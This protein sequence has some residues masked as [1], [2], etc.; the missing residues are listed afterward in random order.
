MKPGNP[1]LKRAR[2]FTLIELLVVIAIIAILAG[3][4]LPALSNAKER[5]HRT[6]CTNNLRQLGIALTMY[7]DDS[8]DNLPPPLFYPEQRP[9]SEPWQGY[10]VFVGNDGQRADTSVPFNLGYLYT[11]SYIDAHKVFYDP[12]MKAPRDIPIKLQLEY[13]EG[14]GVSWPKV[15]GGRV[16][17]N[18]M[19]FPQSRQPYSTT[20][21]AGQEEWRR[22]ARKTSELTS[23]YTITTDL[24]YTEATR[25]HT[26][27]KNPNG[28]NALFG[29][30]HV[31]FSSSS[32]AFAPELW[33]GGKH[34]VGK[35]NPGDNP[36]KFRTIVALLRP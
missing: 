13:Y 5:A 9:S 3:M 28:I 20:P 7:A 15:H 17:I 16:R 4:L 1:N 6:S 31:S 10:Q 11:G 21:S 29:D 34:H 33:D 32:A 8:G 26:T 27:S 30:S 18:Y 22:T 2:G 23:S 19:Y 12:G 36:T 35:Q 24:I 25:P 14:G